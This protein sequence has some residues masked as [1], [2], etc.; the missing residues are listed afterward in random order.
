MAWGDLDES[1]QKSIEDF[2]GAFEH[3]PYASIIE[4]FDKP[5]DRVLA[6]K[7]VGGVAHADTL[8]TPAEE[9][10]QSLHGLPPEYETSRQTMVCRLR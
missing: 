1:L 3:D 2:Q 10:G 5:P 4:I 8:N 6:S 7:V 9:T